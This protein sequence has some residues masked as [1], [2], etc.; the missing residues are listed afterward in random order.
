MKQKENYRIVRI[1]NTLIVIIIFILLLMSSLT[2]IFIHWKFFNSSAYHFSFTP[3]GINTYLT[4][5]GEYKALFTGT[6]ATCAAYFGLHRLNAATQ[7]NMDKLKQDRFLEWKTVQEYRAIEI[8]KVDPYLKKEFV[9]VRYQF[10]QQLYNLN[11]HIND[12][13]ELT[14]LF[15]TIFK[16]LV[17]SFEDMNNKHI[18]MGG[19]YPSSNFAYSFDSFRYLVIGSADTVYPEFIKDLQELYVNELRPDRTI[20][21]AMYKS[22][23]ANYRP[24]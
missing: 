13:E 8:E 12:K 16:D 4:A 11:F 19:V 21:Q 24:I 6:V 15:N 20:D 7:A 17:L 3:T 14:A 1:L 22:A 5:F 10:F 18:G 2:I 23:A 9:R